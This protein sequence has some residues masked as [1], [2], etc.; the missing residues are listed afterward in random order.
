MK[1]FNYVVFRWAAL[2]LCIFFICFLAFLRIRPIILANC[3]AKA[4]NVI[5]NA[6]NTAISE[7]VN[8]NNI[9]YSDLAVISTE[10]DGYIT[11][12]QIDVAKVNALKSII[13][14]KIYNIIS[15]KKY[16]TVSI[17]LG[18]F[19]FDDYTNGYG[20][21]IDFRMQFSHLAN[22]D[23]KSGFI[24]QGIN[25]VLHQI[26]IN[27]DVNGGVL[28]VGCKKPINIKTSFI[29]AQTVIT[30]KIPESFTNVLEDD[31]SDVAD[32]IFNYAD[33]K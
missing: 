24:S 17:P 9:V 10:K 32:K 26:I 11:G 3:I 16:Y 18:D 20:P 21:F 1:K 7:T 15:K 19:L 8:E 31:G 14:S 4:K 12:V 33:I 30:G 5:N 29:I 28:A 2:I 22:L 6:I 27:I 13:S 23:F 25:N